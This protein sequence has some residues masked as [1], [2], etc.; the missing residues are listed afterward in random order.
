[1][2]ISSRPRGRKRIEDKSNGFGDGRRGRSNGP[3]DG[4]KGSIRR[5]STTG[6]ISRLG[7]WRKMG[8]LEAMNGDGVS[9]G[10][11]LEAKGMRKT[12]KNFVG[13]L[14]KRG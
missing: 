9:S 8:R 6:R 13:A 3:E 11:N 5:P 12:L 4:R 7:V 10:A 14:V 2:G 1:V